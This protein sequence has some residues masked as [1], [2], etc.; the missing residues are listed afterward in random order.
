MERVLRMADG[1]VL[2]VDAQEGPMPQTFFVVK[3]ALAA[4]L[5]ILVVINKIDKPAAR[6]DWAVDQVF[7]LLDR[8]DAP[9]HILDFRW[10][11]PRPRPATPLPSRIPRL[12]RK[13]A[14]ARYRR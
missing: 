6:C 3:K 2:L 1:A 14:C 5:P 7:G 12:R 13:P 8:L 10:S 11:T 9:D 4:G